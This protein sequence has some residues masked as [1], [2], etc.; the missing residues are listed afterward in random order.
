MD[1]IWNIECQESLKGRFTENS[2]KRNGKV[3]LNLVAVQKV[4]GVEGGS[5]P[6]DDYTHFYGNG[7]ANYHVVTGF[8]ELKENHVS[9]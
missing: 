5:Q 4:R 9:S 6:P 1:E 7:N 8:F 3:Y 2:G